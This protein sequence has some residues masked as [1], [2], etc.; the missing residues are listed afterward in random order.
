MY[1]IVNMKLEDYLSEIDYT[2][3]GERYLTE[4][5]FIHASTPKQFF[6]VST[7]FMNEKMK[8]ICLVI[9]T[10]KL[11]STIKFE[12]ASDKDYYPHIYGRINVEAVYEVFTYENDEKGLFLPPKGYEKYF[13]ESE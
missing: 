7:R 11:E 5:G 6:K 8:L 2:Y 10:N 9:D 13:N 4:A 3:L 12:Q 1:I